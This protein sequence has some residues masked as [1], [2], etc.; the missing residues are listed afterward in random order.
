MNYHERNQKQSSVYIKGP[1]QPTEAFFQDFE[2][3]DPHNLVL[4]GKDIQ[5]IYL[6]RIRRPQNQALNQTIEERFQEETDSPKK[7]QHLIQN[8]ESD[9]TENYDFDMTAEKPI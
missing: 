7:A 5:S 1:V 4:K 6:A 2:Q 9:L 3:A 8:M